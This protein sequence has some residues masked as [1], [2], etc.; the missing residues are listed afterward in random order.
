MLL[1]FNVGGN[2]YRV[3]LTDQRESEGSDEL[4]QWNDGSRRGISPILSLLTPICHLP[5]LETASL[6]TTGFSLLF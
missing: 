1:I 5:T 2:L 6:N 4:R 3:P